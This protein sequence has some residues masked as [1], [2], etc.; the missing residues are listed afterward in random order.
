MLQNNDQDNKYKAILDSDELLY[1]EKSLGEK[2][3]D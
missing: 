3:C 2:S 1:L